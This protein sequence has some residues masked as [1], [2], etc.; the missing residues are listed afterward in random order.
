MANFNW[1]KLDDLIDSS[2]PTI[3][4]NTI[5][6]KTQLQKLEDEFFQLREDDKDFEIAYSESDLFEWMAEH[7]II[8]TTL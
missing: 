2:D 4:R 6:I 8:K 5:S 1:I 7:E 3:K